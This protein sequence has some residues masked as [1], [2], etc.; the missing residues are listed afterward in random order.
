MKKVE[1][2]LFDLD[3]TL[4]DSIDVYWR[5]FKEV[6]KRLGLP[7]G[8]KEKI[9]DTMLKG[10]NPWVDLFPEI[11][12]DKDILRKAKEVERDLWPWVYRKYV[13]VF[14]EASDLLKK[15]KSM[16]ILTGIITSSWFEEDDPKEILE[17]KKMADAV[18]TKF[19][20]KMVKPD[21]E[22]ILKCCEKLEIPPNKAI[23]VGD[24]PVDIKAG[25]AAGVITIGV[26]WG[27]SDFETMKNEGPDYIAKDFS[28]ALKIIHL[29]LSSDSNGL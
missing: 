29:E 24:A 4:I 8:E 2:V 13:R 16:G 25:K 10:R 5:V 14:P 23:Y 26:L 6:L 21:P 3:G 27:L 18:V 17:L 22:P 20:V 7:L 12:N 19:D 11:S 15:L 1:A 9:I 28:E